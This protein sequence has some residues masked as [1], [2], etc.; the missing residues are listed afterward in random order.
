[1]T[2]LLLN[3]DELRQAVTIPDA[4]NA[5]QTV[6][7]ALAEGRM[8]M[9]GAF[10]LNLPQ[11]NAEVEAR[12]AYLNENPYFVIK[13]RSNFQNNPNINLPAH[14]GLMTVF[15]AATG[16]PAA[17]L[18]DNGYITTISAG[19][20]G[21]LTAKHLANKEIHNVAVIGTGKQA[22][23]QIKALMAVRQFE[24]VSVWGRTPLHTDNYARLIIE[25]H[26][27]NVQIATSP[28]AAVANADVIITATA[29][30]TPLLEADWLKPGVHII[31]VGSNQSQK[32]ELAPEV[33]GRAEVIIVDN[34]QQCAAGGE[35]YH[36][37][38]SGIISETDV[39]GELGGLITGK[40][41]GRTTPDQITVAD[42][43]GLDVQD[44]G[45]ATLALS[46]AQFLGLG[47]QVP[48]SMMHNTL[49][50]LG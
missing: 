5:V 49:S 29:S 2:L 24:Q 22:F 18:V 42:L 36:A 33:F 4:I 23:I 14:H 17:I 25:D 1:M 11:V 40:I 34:L 20:A 37:L 12:G 45:V 8:M 19:A 30:P 15:D 50:R 43:T 21:A 31:A 32:H 6:F 13:V 41:P 7:V 48:I 46:Q 27:L 47:Q 35:I 38:K 44:T 28:E 39:Q 3:E 9:P 16:F 10:T 26:D